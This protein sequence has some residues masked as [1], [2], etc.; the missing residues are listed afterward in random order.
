MAPLISGTLLA[1]RHRGLAYGVSPPLRCQQTKLAAV[2]RRRERDEHQHIHGQPPL[3]IPTGHNSQH[4]GL[5]SL[6]VSDSPLRRR[7]TSRSSKEPVEHGAL[8]PQPTSSAFPYTTQRGLS[9]KQNPDDIIDLTLDNS[10]V[11]FSETPGKGSPSR[12][13]SSNLRSTLAPLPS[14]RTPS[15]PSIHGFSM[16]STILGP[17]L[18]LTKEPHDKPR[19]FVR[20]TVDFEVGLAN[21]SAHGFV[22][23]IYMTPRW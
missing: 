19:S 8:E 4:P 2:R 3:S 12:N 20:Y 6:E 5:E 16:G 22:D 7:T 1:V 21:I 18:N 13:G 14:E 9:V 10:D 17:F 15:E 11:E 23:Q